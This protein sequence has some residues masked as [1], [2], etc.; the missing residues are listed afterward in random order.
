[1]KFTSK[2]VLFGPLVRRLITRSAKSADLS[3]SIARRMTVE[4]KQSFVFPF[5]S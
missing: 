2:A 3:L 4:N 1:M 5:G